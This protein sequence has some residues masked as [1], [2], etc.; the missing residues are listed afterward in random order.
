MKRAKKNWFL[1]VGYRKQTNHRWKKKLNGR[2]GIVNRV[3]IG[4][5]KNHQNNENKMSRNMPVL[6]LHRSIWFEWRMVGRF[7]RIDHPR[8]D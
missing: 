4:Q 1:R 6:K 8:Q 5:K 3:N 7:T 2:K